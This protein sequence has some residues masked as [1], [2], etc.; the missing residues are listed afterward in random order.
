MS[1][2]FPHVPAAFINAIAD[3]GTK[4]EAIEWLEKQWTETCALR[5]V[6]QSIKAA[7]VI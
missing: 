7:S 1:K 4:A 6:L 2:P 5:A 3:S